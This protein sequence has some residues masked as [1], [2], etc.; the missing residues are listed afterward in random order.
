MQ[1]GETMNLFK[2]FKLLIPYLSEVL[3]G[4]DPELKSKNPKI[5]KILDDV[6]RRSRALILFLILSLTLNYKLINKLIDGNL[7]YVEV[8]NETTDNKQ[9]VNPPEVKQEIK[10][11]NKTVT[12]KNK[13]ENEFEYTVRELGL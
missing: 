3:F 10:E 11:N 8:K 5:A 1:E 13:K 12:R 2:F 9:R 4:H 6:K 7:K